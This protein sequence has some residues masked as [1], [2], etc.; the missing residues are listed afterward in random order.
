MQLRLLQQQAMAYITPM[1]DVFAQTSCPVKVTM[2]WFNC[3]YAPEYV[4]GYVDATNLGE[5]L[6][7]AEFWVDMR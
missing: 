4:K 2:T 5:S 1:Q 7:L 6:H 3:R